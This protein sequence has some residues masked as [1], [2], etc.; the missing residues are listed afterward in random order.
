MTSDLPE[1]LALAARCEVAPGPSLTLD[2]LVYE[3]LQRL[4]GV[5]AAEDVGRAILKRRLWMGR[6]Y[7]GSVAAA[8]APVPAGSWWETSREGEGY[9]AWVL[10]GNHTGTAA[11]RTVPLAVLGAAL[12]ALQASLDAGHREGP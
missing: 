2:R 1:L 4:S 6:P 11:A 3:A 8:L 10:H 5:D 12:R 9:K 7:T